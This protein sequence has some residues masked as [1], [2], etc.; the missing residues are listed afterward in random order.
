MKGYRKKKLSRKSVKHP[1]P[2]A[3]P[4][5]TPGGNFAPGVYQAPSL[6]AGA[7]QAPLLNAR[8]AEPEAHEAEEDRLSTQEQ[9]E[10]KETNE[11]NGNLKEE[12]LPRSIILPAE[13]EEDEEHL[14]LLRESLRSE[15]RKDEESDNECASVVPVEAEIEDE[16]LRSLRQPIKSNIEGPSF[17]PVEGETEEEHLNPIIEE[18]EKSEKEAHE[19]KKVDDG[20]K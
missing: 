2:R 13:G 17:F 14:A 18:Q 15:E 19:K 4:R 6:T 1:Q 5:M 8:G 16:R 12:E 20:G 11:V 10:T 9:Q 3:S 7:H